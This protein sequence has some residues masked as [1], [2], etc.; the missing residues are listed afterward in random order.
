MFLERPG[1]R[2][3]VLEDGFALIAIALLAT[4]A[5][6]VCTEVVMRYAGAAG[7]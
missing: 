7:R 6:A 2:S 5:Q 1:R 4:V 3:R